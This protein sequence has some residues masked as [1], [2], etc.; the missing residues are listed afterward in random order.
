MTCD[1][2]LRIP[3]TPPASLVMWHDKKGLV[4]TFHQSKCTTCGELLFEEPNTP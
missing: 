3:Y 1:H 2:L 4:V